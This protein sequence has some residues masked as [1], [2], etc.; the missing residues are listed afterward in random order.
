MTVTYTKQVSRCGDCPNYPFCEAG[1]ETRHDPPPAACPLRRP[2][3][4]DWVRVE[5]ALPVAPDGE[6]CATV[7][8]WDGKTVMEEEFGEVFEQPAGPAVGGWVSI[9]FMFSRDDV[10][11]WRKHITPAPPT[12]DKQ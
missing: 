12:G 10:T 2:L 4:E 6:D 3:G 5:D 11:H 8:T 7:W 1:P 9:G